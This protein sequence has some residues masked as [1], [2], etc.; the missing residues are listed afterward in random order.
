MS[1]SRIASGTN[2]R[3][4][5]GDVI[6]GMGFDRPSGWGYT[7]VY[8]CIKINIRSHLFAELQKLLSKKML[9]VLFE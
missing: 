6:A 7:N 2:T 9:L 3:F 5:L 8:Q 1:S 4:G